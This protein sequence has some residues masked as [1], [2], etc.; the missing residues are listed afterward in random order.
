MLVGCPY[1]VG[2]LRDQECAAPKAYD[3]AVPQRGE[4]V[5]CGVCKTRDGGDDHYFPPLF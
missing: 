3:A 4:A 5:D 1:S 2:I